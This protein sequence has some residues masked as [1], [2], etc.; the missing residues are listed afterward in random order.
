MPD[1]EVV[2]YPAASPRISL[3][4]R[5]TENVRHRFTQIGIACDF[6]ICENLCPSVDDL[7]LNSEMTLAGN[8]YRLGIDEIAIRANKFEEHKPGK[9]WDDILKKG[10]SG[11]EGI[12]WLYP[13][14]PKPWDE[15]T[16]R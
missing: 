16:S 10:R 6:P 9:R 2:T 7:F 3:L 14:I 11:S 8:V 5:S 12:P 1:H 15:K 13:Q 4:D